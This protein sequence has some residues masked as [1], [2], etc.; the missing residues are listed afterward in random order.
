MPKGKKTKEQALKDCKDP[1]SKLFGRKVIWANED[2][3]WHC[4]KDINNTPY[5]ATQAIDVATGKRY[6][7]QDGLW[8]LP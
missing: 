6:L 7:H 2:R 5:W 4:A 1:K 8:I 3:V